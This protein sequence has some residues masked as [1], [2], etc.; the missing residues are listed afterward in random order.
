MRKF[1][2]TQSGF[3]LLE[4]M[5]V[6]VVVGILASVAYPSY[7]DSVRKSRRADAKAALSQLAQFMERNYSLAQR[8]DQTSA[9]AAIAL[10]FSQ[11]PVDGGA[12]QY[13]I[14]I[15]SVAQQTFTLKAV[16]QGAQA[17]DVCGDLTL[18]NAGTKT[19]SG[20]GTGCW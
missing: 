19:A 6:V 5:I 10:P 1:M 4:L 11:S 7:M 13:V 17:S 18:D 9:G 15:D 2:A 8:Y 16:P 12:A 14:S 20:S 3:S